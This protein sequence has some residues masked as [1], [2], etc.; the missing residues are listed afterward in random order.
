MAF[1]LF[2]RVVL[3]SNALRKRLKR[4]DGIARRSPRP[5]RLDLSHARLASSMAAGPVDTPEHSEQ[6]ALT[7]QERQARLD[8]LK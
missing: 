8:Q 6:E 4:V 2:R 3:W 7:D 5:T 1:L